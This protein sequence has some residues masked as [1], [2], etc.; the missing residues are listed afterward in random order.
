[1]GDENMATMKTSKHELEKARW[2]KNIREFNESGLTVRDWC[3]SKGISHGSY[4]YWL[5]V[6][7]EDSLIKAGTLAVTGQSQF[8]E[9]KAKLDTK[10]ESNPNNQLTCA[11]LRSKG[12][13]IE[14][15]NG[16]DLATL[17]MI[18]NLIGQ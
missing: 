17:S 13:E 14:I 3:R 15:F 5:K 4:Y 6:I 11:I 16:A 18:L 2:I 7:R 12:N 1:M 8:V 10:D 9:L